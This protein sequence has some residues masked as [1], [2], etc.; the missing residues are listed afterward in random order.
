MIDDSFDINSKIDGGAY[1]YDIGE[2]YEFSTEE[3]AFGTCYRVSHSAHSTGFD[4][5]VF[6]TNFIIDVR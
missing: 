2:E 6:N 3:T 1:S 5:R 4:E